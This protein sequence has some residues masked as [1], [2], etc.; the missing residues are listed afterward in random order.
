MSLKE[1][2]DKIKYSN[3]FSLISYEILTQ[4]NES[5]QHPNMPWICCCGCGLGGCLVEESTDDFNWGYDI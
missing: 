1:S 3:K 4:Y 5:C 2:N